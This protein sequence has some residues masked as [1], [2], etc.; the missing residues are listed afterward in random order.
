MDIEIIVIGESGKRVLSDSRIRIGQDPNCEVSLPP[1]K[2]AAVAGVHLTLEVVNGAVSLARG[3]PLGGET[4]VNGHPAAAGAAIR[5]G[6]ILRLGAGGPELRIRLLE[7]EAYA[8]P[9]QHEPTR[10]LT[11]EPT[12]VV[13]GPAAAAYSPPP[14]VAQAAMGRQGYTAEVSR[15]VPSIPSNPVPQPAANAAEGEDMS[16]LESKVKTLQSILVTTLLMIL[17]L[18]GC[19][20]W[21]SWE[22]SL[23]RDDVQLLRT[24]ATNAVAQ[25]TPQLD[26]RLAVFEQRMDGMDA[27]IADAQDRMVKTMDAQTKREEDRMVERMNTAIP[28]MLDKYIANKYAEMKH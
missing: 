19:N 18:L 26:A 15:V 11:H 20:I 14:P 12:R 13:T 21:Q 23:T 6:D 7:Q 27:K 2:Y 4:F 8:P 3:V 16:I 1:G 24:Q 5:S 25:L 9:A 17:V 10:V 22:L 28:A